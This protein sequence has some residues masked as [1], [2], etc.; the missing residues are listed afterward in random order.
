[1]FALVALRLGVGWQFY[2]EGATKLQSAKPYSSYFLA[3]ARGPLAPLFQGMI[4]DVDGV[5]RLQQDE[6]IE[7]W[8]HYRDRAAKHYGFT[9]EQNVK[10]EAIF[11]RYSTELDLFFESNRADIEQHLLEV[12]R[13][14]RDANPKNAKTAPMRE[15]ASLAGQLAERRAESKA[16]STPWIRKV[17]G[18]WSGF[19]TDINALANGTQIEAETFVLERPGRRLIDSESIDMFIRCFDATIGI[20]LMVG[21]FTRISSVLAACFLLSVVASQWPPTTGPT[22]TYYHLNL[23]LASLVLAATGAGRFGGLDFFVSSL[24]AKCCSKKRGSD[25]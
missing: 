11:Q 4:W 12:Q 2:Q 8:E 9:E 14:D 24:W 1:M 23:A 17:D 13:Q 3:S 7:S 22:S 16:T 10:A 6:T 18:M 21:L 15:V 25:A 19:E 20:L 5:A